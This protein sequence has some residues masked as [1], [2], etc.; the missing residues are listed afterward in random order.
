MGQLLKRYSHLGIVFILI[1]FFSAVTLAQNNPFKINDKL[2]PLYQRAV[3]HRN[4][5]LGLHIADTLFNKADKLHDKKAQCLAL[6]IPIVRYYNINPSERPDHDKYLKLFTSAVERLKDFSRRTGYEQYYYYACTNY[7]NFILTFAK[8]L[9][10]LEYAQKMYADAK[11]RNSKIG[12]YNSLKA[13]GNVHFVR[14]EQHLAIK[15]YN[16]A[17]DYAKKNFNLDTYSELYYKLATCYYYGGLFD[18]AI[19]YTNM[20]E[21]VSKNDIT[22][23]RAKSIRC[24]SYFF[25]G[26]YDKFIALYNEIS[27]EIHKKDNLPTSN[28][29]YVDVVYNIYMKDYQQALDVCNDI[30]YIKQRAMLTSLVYE[31]SG[32]YLKA[33]EQS[34]IYYAACDS[35]NEK[36]SLQDILHME[37]VL[38]KYLLDSEEQEIELQNTNLALSNS[39][40]NLEAAKEAAENEKINSQNSLIAYKNTELEAKN[41]RMLYDKQAMEQKRRNEEISDSHILTKAL[42]YTTCSIVVV[43]A[44]LLVSRTRLQ[45]KLRLKHAHLQHNNNVLTIARR[46]AEEADHLKTA[47]IHNMS[48][49]IRTP[50]NAIVGF[51]QILAENGSDLSEK[52]KAD[53]SNR[54]EES[55]DLVLTIINDIL[56]ITS[57]ESGHYKMRKSIIA[58][59]DFCRKIIT[60]FKNRIPNGVELR[61]STDIDDSL[62]IFSDPKRIWQ[63][64][65]NLITNSAKYTDSGFITVEVS[66]TEQE[67]YLSFAVA[68]TGSGIPADKADMIFD[69]FYKGDT[70]KQGVGLGLSICKSIAEY[71]NGKI[72]LDKNYYQRGARFV[73]ALPI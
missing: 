45:K 34:K 28:T 55:S 30:P 52:E 72:Y 66:A 61:F 67:G 31:H 57:I 73:F 65:S 63:V 46:E 47:F 25:T 8:E 38:D 68:D 9:N 41:I 40:L 19:K 36:S 3:L 7:I 42:L 32:N 51:S 70:F 49:E 20:T 4:S 54:I 35:I 2:Y 39:R 24:T 69:R 11:H 33:L 62:T 6:T 48:H 22:R 1:F 56:D 15:Q 10:A 44:F 18:E 53:F 43:L 29:S 58:V 64:L 23:L 59:N 17:L 16:E 71:M 26:N 60:D 5:D 12:I 14:E 27:P 13:L 50:L 37:N 21:E